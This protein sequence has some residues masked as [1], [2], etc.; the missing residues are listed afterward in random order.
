VTTTVD[1]VTTVRPLAPLSLEDAGL[2]SD[3]VYD[4]VRKAL[5]AGGQSG[6]ELAKRIGLPFAAIEPSLN[7][8][9]AQLQCEIVGGSMLGAASYRYRLTDLGQART[10]GILQRNQ[11][12]GVAPV[13]LAQYRQYMDQFAAVTS[14]AVTPADVREAFANL[15]VS[16]DVLDELGPAI[17]ARHSIFIYGPPGNGK[18]QM[19]QTIQKLLTGPIAVPHALEVHGQIIR[20]FDPTIHHP[21]PGVDADDAT[22]RYDRRWVVCKRPAVSVGGELTLEALGLA[23]SERSGIYRA[24]VQT[25]ANGGVLIVDDFGRQQCAPRDLLNWWMVPLETRIE[26]MALLSGEKIEMPFQALVIFSTNIR[27]ADLV[28]EAFLRRIRYKIYAANPSREEFIRIFERC[29]RDEHVV[30]H[31]SLVEDLLDR[32]YTPRGI[33]PRGCQPRDLI[34]QAIAFASYRGQAREL[35]PELLEAACA[36]YFITDVDESLSDSP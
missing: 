3:M 26:Y 8:L 1:G 20:F 14:S 2:S 13:P 32:Y 35:T 30:F 15:V 19:A 25:L 29:C 34:K 12:S 10:Q 31:R 28:D 33:R 11:Y 24:P 5:Y 23:F 21:W 22:H 6:Q 4:L 7:L 9:K 17:N 36:S 27:P 18:S 16:Q